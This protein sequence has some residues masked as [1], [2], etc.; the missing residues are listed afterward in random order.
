MN[1]FII[2][3]IAMIA[4]IAMPAN[5]WDLGNG[6]KVSINANA[7]YDAENESPISGAIEPR[8]SYAMGQK[9]SLYVQPHVV[10]GKR[11]P[12]VA[13]GSCA[14]CGPTLIYDYNDRNYVRLGLDYQM[15]PN[16][17]AGFA[18]DVNERGDNTQASFLI[19]VHFE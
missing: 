11:N 6:F 19:S 15:S 9:A 14:K 8:I 1:R 13:A 18:L 12:I 5:A 2:A 17:T 10:L 4:M 16:V 3:I 7:G